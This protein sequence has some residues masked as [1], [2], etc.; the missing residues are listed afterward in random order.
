[1][2]VLRNCIEAR[3]TLNVLAW[4]DD[5]IAIKVR[6]SIAMANDFADCR[7]LANQFGD[8][9]DKRSFLFRRASVFSLATCI[10]SAYIAYAYGGGIVA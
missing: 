7:I 2:L 8:K 6:R 9:L 10:K 1:M 3:T 4:F 5:T